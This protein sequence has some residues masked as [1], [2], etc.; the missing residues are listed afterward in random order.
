MYKELAKESEGEFNCLGKNTEKY[1]IFLVP[2][3]KEVKRIDKNGKEITK[4]ISYKLPF[5]DSPRFFASS[6]SN[7]ADD[8]AKKVH[9]IKCKY[10]HANRK[11]ETCEIKYK[12]YT[13]IK[14]DLKECKYSCC[15]QNY[16]KQFDEN[17]M[18]IC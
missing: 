9:K 7:L 8:I 17:L 3:T 10:G 13:S 1:K 11:C 18:E 12:E 14:D 5:I 15:N 2:I 6:L 16:Q 4:T